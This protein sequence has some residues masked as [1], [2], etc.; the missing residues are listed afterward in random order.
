VGK[1]AY[2]VC[3]LA[4]ILRLSTIKSPTGIE[5]VTRLNLGLPTLSAKSREFKRILSFEDA[6]L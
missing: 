4:C 3:G 5:C 1:T 2:N 6:F